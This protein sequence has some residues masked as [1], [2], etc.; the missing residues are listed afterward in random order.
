M[1][2]F[3]PFGTLF[4]YFAFRFIGWICL[5]LF[6]L[7]SIISLTQTIELVRRVSVLTRRV[8]TLTRRT[9]SIV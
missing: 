7:V 6:S 2:Q 5:C 3:A 8:N 4:R 9:S 1:S